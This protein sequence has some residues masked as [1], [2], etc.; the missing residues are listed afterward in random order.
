MV[1]IGFIS[2]Y[3]NKISVGSTRIDKFEAVVTPASKNWH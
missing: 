2:C 3:E 1:N